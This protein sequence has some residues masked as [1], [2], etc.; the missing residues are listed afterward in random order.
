[1]RRVKSKGFTLVELLV[2]IAIIG[3]L[4]ALLLPAVQAAREAARRIQCAG[5]FKQVGLALH[6]YSASHRCFPPG[7]TWDWSKNYY[8]WSWSAFVIPHLEA[9]T[10]SDSIDF[11]TAYW[12]QSGR[13]AGAYSLPIYNCPS[14]PQAGGWTEWASG[15]HLGKTAVED[16]RTTSIVGVADSHRW[17]QNDAYGANRNGMFFA[18]TPIRISDVSDGTSSTLFIGEVTGVRGH[19]GDGDGWYQHTWYTYNCHDLEKGINGP[20]TLPGGRND[21]PTGD[22]IDGAGYPSSNRH[23]ELFAEVGFSSWHPAGC[24]FGMVDGSVHFFTNDIDLGVLQAL[25][26]RAGGETVDAEFY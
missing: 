24:H 8:G 10:L 9:G 2:V 17:E 3:I 15:F 18:N 12:K 25:A 1:M 6:N 14:D 13:E 11:Q 20:T 16:Y 22:P 4:I 26:T 21:S 5:N 19:C 7:A 23:N